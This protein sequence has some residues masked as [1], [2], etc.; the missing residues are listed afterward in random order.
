MGTFNFTFNEMLNLELH[1]AA[2]VSKIL[3]LKAKI[4]VLIFV[5]N[6]NPTDAQKNIISFFVV[7]TIFF[8]GASKKCKIIKL[9]NSRI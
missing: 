4:Y 3:R 9:Y 2:A 1:L 5:Y 7:F 6:F 8:Q